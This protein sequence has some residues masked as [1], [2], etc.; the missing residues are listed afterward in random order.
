MRIKDER[1]REREKLENKR[2]WEERG[3]EGIVNGT[4]H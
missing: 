1:E 4:R 2:K 3:R